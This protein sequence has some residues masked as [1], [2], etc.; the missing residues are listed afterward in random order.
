VVGRVNC[1]KCFSIPSFL[2]LWL[3]S[4][5]IFCSLLWS[6]YTS[7]LVC[8]SVIFLVCGYSKTKRMKNYNSPCAI[9][10]CLCVSAGTYIILGKN[11]CPT[12]VC[13]YFYRNF[14]TNVDEVTS[15][16]SIVS[17]LKYCLQFF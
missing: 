16:I 6:H 11:S 13:Y 1:R 10:G 15:K 3:S 12:Y 17:I 14:N 4:I 2:I 7:T 8:I 5:T 9:N